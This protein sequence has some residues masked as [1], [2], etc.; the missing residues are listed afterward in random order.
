MSALSSNKLKQARRLQK[1]GK[2][3]QSLALYEK[4]LQRDPGNA[5]L[6]YQTGL[7]L[8]EAGHLQ[9]AVS[10]LNSAVTLG[11][12][13]ADIFADLAL[14]MN[15]AYQYEQAETMA[16][17][18]V[19]L[20]QKHHRGLY[21]LLDVLF[22]QGKYAEAIPVAKMLLGHPAVTAKERVLIARTFTATGQYSIAV[23]LVEAIIRQDPKVAEAHLLLSQVYMDVLKW[24]EGLES[25]QM[26]LELAP[27]NAAFIANKAHILEHHGRFEEAFALVEPLTRTGD[28]RNA[29]AFHVYARLAKRFGKTEHAV[30]LLEKLG[31]DP[32][33]SVG[34][35]H[36][37]FNLLGTAYDALGQYD[38]AFAAITRGNELRPMFYQDELHEQSVNNTMEWFSAEQFRKLSGVTAGKSQHELQ[39][40]FI[41]GMPR[42]GT[43]L[44]EKILA[45]HPRVHAG[46]ELPHV[47]TLI[48]N[49]L[50]LMLS[51]ADGFPA[52]LRALNEEIAIAA[53]GI[54]HEQIAEI[55]P[56]GVSFVTDKMP[57]NYMFLGA[58]AALFPRAKIIHCNRDPMA[59]GLSCYF[60]N[61]ASAT[62]LGFSQSLELIGSYT[63]RYQRL[64]AHWRSVLST[65]IYDVSY[66]NLVS[67]P[68]VEIAR[69]LEF[70]ELPWD[71]ACLS[72][73]DAAQTTKTA[74]YNQVRRAINTH[75]IERWRRYEKQ[76]Q[77]LKAVLGLNDSQAA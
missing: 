59:V 3:G 46:G 11:I 58:I 55:A 44:T 25:A 75:S 15:R 54:Y 36:T 1:A 32:S 9:Q 21:Q 70:C 47:A 37:T 8:R 66:E 20:D 49:D 71:E 42:S 76:L 52:N 72:P 2:L 41:V 74:S 69:L 30:Q 26:A 5:G 53:A 77:P 34:V 68:E 48:H 14:C 4:L 56:E 6:H 35:R 64:M 27:N 10:Y 51:V 61:F 19:A 57:M 12:Q 45:R 62:D 16:R 65:P 18:S 28:V 50:P 60:T 43:S 31:N 29:A 22:T 33:R 23:E 17:A 63:L 24:D 73:Q 67:N 40:I 39:P 7:V 38:K 13:S